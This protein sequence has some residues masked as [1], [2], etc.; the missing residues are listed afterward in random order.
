MSYPPPPQYPQGQQPPG[1]Y[2]SPGYPPGHYGPG[3][4]SSD[5]YPPGQYPP[6]QGPPQDQ[7][8]QRRGGCRGCLLGCL[9]A[10]LVA[11]A[12]TV[13]AVVAGAYMIR[14]MFPTTESVQEAAT[15][16]IL[17]V[18]VNNAES[19]IEQADATAAEQAEMRRGV[20][21]LRAEFERKCGPLR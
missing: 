9:I 15:C 13:V 18:V 2:P 1:Q 16:T 12:L 20:Q 8:V 5:Q 6:N 3:Q 7:P 19:V 4:Y 14:Q 21:D 11:A 17:R 10:F